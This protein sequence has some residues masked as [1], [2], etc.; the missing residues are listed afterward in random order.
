MDDLHVAFY[1]RFTSK[2]RKRCRTVCQTP[3]G[4]LVAQTRHGLYPVTRTGQL[5]RK[6]RYL[7]SIG[8]VELWEFRGEKHRSITLHEINDI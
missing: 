1:E 5:N 3:S 7:G 6:R 2:G 4:T 8:T